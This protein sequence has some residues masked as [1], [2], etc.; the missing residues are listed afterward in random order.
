MTP[1]TR[2][3]VITGLGAVTS[4]G[5][6][7]GAFWQALAAGESGVAPLMAFDGRD[8]R[9]GYAAEV[10]AF[11]PEDAGIARK[12]LKVMGRPAQLAYAAACEACA[13]AGLADGAVPGGPARIGVMLGIGMLNADVVELG[14]TFWATAATTIDRGFDLAAFGRAATEQMSPLWLLRHIP[15]LAAAHVAIGF[16]AQAPSN[17]IATGCVAGANAIG[18]AARV[19]ARDDADVMLAGGTDA[20]V[21]PLAMLRYRGLRWLSTRDDVEPQD[22]SAP[23]DADASG[24]VNGEGAGV[25]VLESHEHAQA[26]GA[27][28]LAELAGYGAAN[29]AHGFLLPRPDGAALRRAMDRALERAAVRMSD[30]DVLFAPAPAVPAYDAAV[31][32]ALDGAHAR[33]PLVTATRSVL[34]HTHAASAALDGV[35]AVRALQEQCVPPTR[36]LKR[37]IAALALVGDSPVRRHLETVVVGAN[38]FGGHAAAF[39]LRRYA[40]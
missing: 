21:T 9:P 25:L 36:N 1:T 19:I 40:A 17:T 6:T 20:R 4:I 22:V 24:F 15:N 30:V 37:P 12:K 34:G 18:E 38:G 31:A 39:V 27:R 13:D 8:A 16:D 28:I 32:A 5:R 14:R 11:A 29:D 33:G 26:R 35:A 7:A 23:F 3:V 10:K 2:R